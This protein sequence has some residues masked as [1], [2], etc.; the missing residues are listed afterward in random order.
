MSKLRIAVLED[1]ASLLKEL[2]GRLRRSGL[3]EVVAYARDRH[4]F[5]AEVN[6]KNPDGLILDIDLSGEPD[7][8]LRVARELNLPVLFISGHVGNYL[9]AIELLDA[10]RTRLPVA[11]LSKMCT[12]EVL[13]NR[14]SKFVDEVQALRTQRRVTIRVKG[15]GSTIT[16][17][18]DSIVAIVVDGGGAGSNNKRVLFTRDKP[19]L[20]ADV[21]L[22]RLAD[23]GFPSE[24][25]VRISNQCAVNRS[26]VLEWTGSAVK[27]RYMESDGTLTTQVLPIK[28]S[29]RAKVH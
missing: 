15:S 19:V 10:Q 2:V 1:D 9:L 11:H 14:L 24:A 26:N 22:S 21:S 8:G 3:V 18:L 23:F 5:M 28:E 16:P 25:F 27:V 13:R 7:G 12:E 6:A 4:E 17:G 20:V 29:F